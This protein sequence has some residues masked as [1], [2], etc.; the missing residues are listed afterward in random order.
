MAAF[1]G[2][3]SGFSRPRTASIGARCASRSAIPLIVVATLLATIWLNYDLFRYHTNYGLFP[4]QD[5]GLIIGSIQA[6][7]SISFQSME[8][9]FKE[10]QTIVQNDPAVASV[11]GFTG[12]RQTNSGFIYVSLKPQ[13]ERKVSADDVVNRLRGKLAQVAGAR[14]FMVAVS[15]LRT[16]G[17]QSNATYQYTLLSDDTAELYKWSPKLT[18]ALMKSDVIKDVNSDQQQG[19]LE[20]DIVI[21]RDTAMRLGLT[22]ERNRQHALRRL[23]P[24]AGFGHLQCAEPVPRGDGGRAALLARSAHAR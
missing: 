20:T 8:Q 1:I 13:A 19:G 17:R 3:R 10:L 5:T 22:L 21:D 23:R 4:V 16:G 6:D 14:L 9:K 12:G 7:Q 2:L 18:E 15:D 24:A 11:V